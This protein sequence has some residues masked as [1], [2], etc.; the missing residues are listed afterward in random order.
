MIYV[1]DEYDD[2][3]S[4]S[5]TKPNIQPLNREIAILL[6]SY[7]QAINKS[8]GRSGS[9]IRSRTKSKC[10]N[11]SGSRDEQYPLTCFLYIH[12]NP[13]KAKLSS[14]LFGWPYSSYRDY[15]GER[16]GNLCSLQLG[17]R[18]LN[19]P[20][21]GKEFEKFSIRSLNEDVVQEIF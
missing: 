4:E 2:D 6:S 8:Y 9:L 12:Q 3:L 1:P 21:D 16:S 10:L 19:L 18:S 5:R 11:K 7:T 15:T 14:S 20:E 17:R 13:L